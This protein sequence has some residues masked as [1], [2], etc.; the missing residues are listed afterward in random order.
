M[1]KTKVA[2][3]ALGALIGIGGAYATT[4]QVISGKVDI[5]TYNWYTPDGQLAFRSTIL[6]ARSACPELVGYVCLRGTAQGIPNVTLF[7][8]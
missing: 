7:K 2:F 3:S 6:P 5:N 4:H 8:R 1:K